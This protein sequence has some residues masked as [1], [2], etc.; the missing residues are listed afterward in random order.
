LKSGGHTL[1]T[2]TDT[3]GAITDIM[4]FQAGTLKARPDDVKAIFRALQN[5]SDYWAANPDDGN[6]IVA[7]TI[8]VPLAD[9]PSLVQSDHI[10]TVADNQVAFDFNNPQSIDKTIKA[11]SDFFIAEKV[12]QQAPDTQA[13]LNGTFVQSLTDKK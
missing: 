2:S 3:P 10:L 8:G 1:F 13:L 11:I 5:A 12:I 9:F 4:M 7:K 6:Q